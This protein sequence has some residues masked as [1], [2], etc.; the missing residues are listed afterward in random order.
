MHFI[1]SK[2]V[3]IA[4]VISL[5]STSASA[6]EKV[7]STASGKAP[8]MEEM[9]DKMPIAKAEKRTK[10]KDDTPEE[11]RAELKDY[12]ES[13]KT[14]RE[15]LSPEAKA[16]LKKRRSHWKGKKH[17]KKKDAVVNKETEDKIK[18]HLQDKK[19]PKMPSEPE[20]PKVK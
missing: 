15:N 7:P 4:A 8:P 19:D 17:H 11:V 3:L 16:V 20:A 1:N 9:K 10:A 6:I 12:H 2:A 18:A 14:L 13:K 5:V